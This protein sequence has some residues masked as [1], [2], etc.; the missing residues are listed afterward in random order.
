MSKVALK[1]RILRRMLGE[2]FNTWQSEVWR[3]DLDGLYCCDGRECCCGGMTVLD[4]HW[5]FYNDR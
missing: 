5:G 2:T 4:A 1:F 3:R